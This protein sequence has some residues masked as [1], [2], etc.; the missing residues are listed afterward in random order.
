MKQTARIISVYTAD[1]MTNY[2]VTIAYMNGILRRAL[3][4]F[5]DVAELIK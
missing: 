4:L 3:G 5:P 2:G 1:V